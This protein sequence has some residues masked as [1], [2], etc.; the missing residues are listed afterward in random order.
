MTKREQERILWMGKA[1]GRM[2][3]DHPAE[4][5]ELISISRKLSR[6]GEADCNGEPGEEHRAKREAR[7]CARAQEI[8]TAA[9][10]R[11]YYQTDPRGAAVYILPGLTAPVGEPDDSYYSSRGVAVY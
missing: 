9:G 10:C 7:L 2:G 6:V 3:I 8:A 11:F 5:S 4:V 1:L